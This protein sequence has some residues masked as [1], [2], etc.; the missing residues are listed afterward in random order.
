MLRPYL[1]KMRK[2]IL[3][4]FLILLLSGLYSR[5][6]YKWFCPSGEPAKSIG[7]K[8][9]QKESTFFKENTTGLIFIK[10]RKNTF[11]MGSPENEPER[12]SDEGPVT[13]VNIDPFYICTTEVRKKDFKRFAVETG[14]RT[15]A[16]KENFSWIYSEITGNW[17]KKNGLSW[18]KPGYEQRLNHPVVHVSFFDAVN[19]AK[20]LSSKNTGCYFR[21]PTEQEWEFA[22]RSGGTEK[23]S[24]FKQICFYANGADLSA[25]KEFSGWKV[26]E[27]NDGFVFTSDAGSFRPNKRGIYDM[28]GNVW[29]WCDSQYRS[30]IFEKN[31]KIYGKRSKVVIR[32]GSF[33][34]KPEYLRFSSRDYLSSPEKRGYDIGFRL[35]M[36]EK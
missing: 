18:K 36:I 6:I 25:K 31:K 12:N 30:R 33:Y 27:C 9:E 22:A 1:F 14:Y 29:E 15:E 23:N 21:L 2:K 28:L 17:E 32:G 7:F 26:S 20:W 10:F 4:A 5:L 19:F 11:L 24:F 3:T 16:E 34:S 13:K 8:E 35:V